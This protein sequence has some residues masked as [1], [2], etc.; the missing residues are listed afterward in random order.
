MMTASGIIA[1]TASLVIVMTAL[2]V[3]TMT[4]SEGRMLTFP[5]TASL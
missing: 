4:A 3:I 1:M 5:M 2:L